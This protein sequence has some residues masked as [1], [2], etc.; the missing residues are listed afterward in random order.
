MAPVGTSVLIHAVGDVAPRRIEAGKPPESLFDA[1]AA[2]IREAD[3][4]VCQLERTLSTRGF[5]G[6]RDAH[7]DGRAWQSRNHP[8][9]VKSL[10][11]AGFHLATFGSNHCFDWGPDALL[12]TIGVLRANGIEVIGAGRDSEEARKPAIFTFR[13]TTIAFLDY[14]CIL[15]DDYEAREGKPGCAGIRI[16]THYEPQEYQPGMPPRIITTPLEEDVVTVESDIRQART[17][18][19]VVVISVHWGVHRIPGLLADYEFSLGHRAIDAGAD[20]II[21]T[22]TH[23]LKGVE[24]YK[25]KVIFHNLGNFG[26]DYEPP[27]SKPPEGAVKALRREQQPRYGYSMKVEKQYSMMMR[28]LIENKR[29]DRV[30]FLPA[31][32]NEKSEP[33]F[34]KADERQFQDIVQYLTNWSSGL[35][36][37]FRTEG[38]EVVVVPTKK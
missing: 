12:D 28:C 22:H 35:G 21:G 30:S 8:D 5:V 33:R 15:P 23:L 11:H 24:V 18:A 10:V 6:D 1:V 4:A 31:L 16:S 29:I 34:L 2:K 20:L 17:K 26:F 14:N 36:S 3:I 19:D 7:A 9:N 27:E 38:D 25:G 32:I 13:G 37:E